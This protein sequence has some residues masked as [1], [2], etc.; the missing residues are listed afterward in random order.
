MASTNAASA[1]HFKR[2]AVCLGRDPRRAE[3]RFCPRRKGDACSVSR[4]SRRESSKDSCSGAWLGS[5]YNSSWSIVELDFRA[6]RSVSCRQKTAEQN[7]YNFFSR[8]ETVQS[9]ERLWIF[10]NWRRRDPRSHAWNYDPVFQ[11]AMVL[12]RQIGTK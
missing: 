3:T 11:S 7:H 8:I 12:R 9:W 10:L 5:G 1:T 2:L 4:S 6:T